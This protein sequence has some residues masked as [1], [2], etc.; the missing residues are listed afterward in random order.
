MTGA[1][2]QHAIDAVITW[3]DGNELAH[4]EKLS[5]YL[6][7]FGQMPAAA[8]PTRF[9]EC[10]ELEYCLTSL[11]RFAP[12]LRKIFIVT[13]NQYPQALER[14][15]D[16][17]LKQRIEIIDHRDIFRGFEHVLPTFN[18]LSI[19]TMLW[20][21][22][23][24]AEQFIYFNDDVMLLKPVTADDFFRDGKPVLR[25]KNK[26]QSAY[27][28]TKRVK[29]WLSTP[30]EP[31]N[32]GFKHSQ[33]Q[34]AQKLGLERRYFRLDHTPHPLKRSTFEQLFAAHP[35]WFTQNIHYKL[36]HRAQFSPVALA[37]HWQLLQQSA[38]R[39]CYKEGL[40]VKPRRYP[41][42]RLRATLAAASTAK[43]ACVQSLDLASTEQFE[44]IT[45]W[46]NQRIKARS[47]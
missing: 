35:D 17:A 13:D 41:L 22:P 38:V 9:R 29:Q 15:Q 37:Y 24:L 46:L 19:E 4:R 7:A 26:L 16:S 43:F 3:V 32:P 5:A 12:F 36:R 21:I 8:H 10:G 11:L 39:G 31:H 25:V 1:E 6:E 2:H 23:N 45:G 33:E 27:R 20:R 40:N 14:L 42:R 34:A 28:L 47:S 30:P 44:V 18:S